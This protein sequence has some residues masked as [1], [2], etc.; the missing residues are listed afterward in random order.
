MHSK[1][2]ADCKTA[3]VKNFPYDFNEDKLGD[4]FRFCGEI[5][6]VRIVYNYVTK[7][8]KGFGYVEFKEH[9]ALVKALSMDA[10]KVGNRQ[11]MVDFETG[12]MKNSYRHNMDLGS[13]S[14]YNKQYVNCRIKECC[15]SRRK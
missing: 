6:N 13:N 9:S 1:P 2:P 15:K 5:E 11:L 12:D 10:Q 4:L 7:N 14:K 3:F 8:S